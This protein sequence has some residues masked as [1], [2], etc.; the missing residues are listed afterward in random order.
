MNARPIEEA[1]DPDLRGSLAALKRAA[2]RA[3]DIAIQTG[4]GIVVSENGVIRHISAQELIRERELEQAR[5]K[6][7]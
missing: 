7:E 2:Q 3:R 4:T 5:N 1:R 6:A